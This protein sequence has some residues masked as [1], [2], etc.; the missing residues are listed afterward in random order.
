[1]TYRALALA[2]L[3]PLLLGGCRGSA[4]IRY[5]TLLPAHAVSPSAPQQDPAFRYALD[6]VTIPAQV[7]TPRIV[8]R[9]GN[10]ELLPV[11]QQRWVAPLADE[12]HAALVNGISNRLGV[13]EV[14]RVGA[15]QRLSLYRVRVEVSRFESK[16]GQ[17]A[18]LDATWSLL[19]SDDPKRSATC[20]SHSE[21]AIAEGFPALAD[22]HQRAVATLAVRIAR[23]LEAVQAG[24]AV[25]A[26][27]AAN[28][29]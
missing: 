19:R 24:N 11:E 17:S 23:G 26:C 13:P 10:S 1:M 16:L 28:R 12:L 21:V 29:D 27:V 15:D 22:G 18:S 6:P 4:A 14:G 9:S 20:S 5:Y 2:L 25:G 8:V 7:D 3:A